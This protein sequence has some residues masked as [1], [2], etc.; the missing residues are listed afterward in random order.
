MNMAAQ[1]KM[2]HAGLKMILRDTDNGE[3]GDL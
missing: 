1:P 2:L 3:N